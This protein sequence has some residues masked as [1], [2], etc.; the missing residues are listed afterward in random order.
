LTTKQVRMDHTISYKRQGLHPSRTEEERG[1]RGGAR[2]LYLC[3]PG[4]TP[5]PEELPFKRAGTIADD[6]K[7]AYRVLFP[8]V[9]F[10]PLG[11]AVPIPTKHHQRPQYQQL[12]P[13]QHPRP[14]PRLYLQPQDARQSDL[15][16]FG[17][18]DLYGPIYEGKTV[19]PVGLFRPRS[20]RAVID[21]ARNAVERTVFGRGSPWRDASQPQDRGILFDRDA[22]YVPVQ[23]AD[24]RVWAKIRDFR[25]SPERQVPE[26]GKAPLPP[27]KEWTWAEFLDRLPASMRSKV[28]SLMEE[29]E[30]RGLSKTITAV[31]FQRSPLYDKYP[32]SQRFFARVM[33]AANG[34]PPEDGYYKFLGWV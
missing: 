14:R 33:A 13:Y 19:V 25:D 22:V 21:Y 3:G 27:P 24:R 2:L 15:L 34:Y 31:E 28:L 1:R 8:D 32:M 30:Q 18:D 20:R 26:R 4:V 16:Q 9:V 11:P 23:V 10:T 29:L 6:W 12:Q 5:F 7:N 17:G